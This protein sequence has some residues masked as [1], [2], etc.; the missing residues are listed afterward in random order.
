MITS[1]LN[2]YCLLFFNLIFFSLSFFILKGTDGIG[3]DAILLG[4]RGDVKNQLEM[5]KEALIDL[6]KADQL[7]PN[8]IFIL[9][10]RFFLFYFYFY[11]FSFICRLFLKLE[12]IRKECYVI[13]KEDYKIFLMLICC[14]IRNMLGQ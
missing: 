3:N 2:L 12:V 1:N 8:D 6:N 4:Q 7:S 5:Y 11:L 9:Q 10:T 13:F 14:L